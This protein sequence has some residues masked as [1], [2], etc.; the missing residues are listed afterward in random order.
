MNR[1]AVFLLIVSFV[2]GCSDNS[3]L[4]GSVV[5]A[6]S[7]S[8]IKGVTIIATTKTDIQ[9]DKKYEIRT[10]STNSQGQFV[11]KGLSPK[12]SYEVTAQKDSYASD[13][14]NITP[15]AEN[16][17]KIIERPLLICPIP[18]KEGISIWESTSWKPLEENITFRVAETGIRPSMAFNTILDIYYPTNI[19][20]TEVVISQLER[21]LEGEHSQLD[22][23]E[24][25][26]TLKSPVLFGIMGRDY[27][28][29]ELM[30]LYYYPKSVIYDQKGGQGYPGTYKI[31]EGYHLGTQKVRGVG[32]CC[33]YLGLERKVS[34]IGISKVCNNSI[35]TLNFGYFN[36]TQPGYYAIVPGGKLDLYQSKGLD[37]LL[38]NG[39]R[40]IVFKAE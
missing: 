32:Q 31:A 5:D 3:K 18:S 38:K 36:I 40:G 14:I 19:G 25:V 29:Y 21:W 13:S 11:L 22:K 27:N 17:T 30:Q 6:I 12:Y 35:G 10:S 39:L 33:R 34:L 23:I 15:E 37:E 9:E 4:Q 28:N 7:K 1:F 20:K 24:N 2:S 16:K 8:P 26:Y